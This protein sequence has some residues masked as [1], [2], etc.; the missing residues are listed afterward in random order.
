MRKQTFVELVGREIDISQLADDMEHIADEVREKQKQSYIGGVAGFLSNWLEQPEEGFARIIAVNNFR[1]ENSVELSNNCLDPSVLSKG[2]I[3]K[4]DSVVLMSGTLIP[5]VMY[6]DLVGFEDS[7]EKTYQNPFPPNNQLNLV[8]P[9]TTTK[10]SKR[11]E[12]QFLDIAKECA[13]ITDSVTGNSILFFPSYY[14]RDRVADSFQKLSKK[15]VFFEGAGMSASERDAL[16]EK[17]RKYSGVG[18]VLLGVVSGSF[19]EG[20]DLPG[21]LLKCVVIVGLPFQQPDLRTKKLIEYYDKKFGK[22]WDYGYVFPAFNKTLQSAG[23]CIRSES[24][25]GVI[26][27]LDERY[28]WSN[29]QRCFPKDMKLKVT[30]DPATDIKNFFGSK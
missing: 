15:T 6:K 23:R 2:I 24:D 17:F 1:G 30:R 25:E 8:V 12:S 4:A 11:S 22:G 16:L 9:K 14:I 21:E 19:Y 18:A 27:F 13:S 28:L 10:Y 26:V 20:I 5:P 3:Q 7:I 29:Y